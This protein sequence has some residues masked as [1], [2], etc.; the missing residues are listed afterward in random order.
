MINTSCIFAAS[1]LLCMS[2]F[3][4]FEH[5]RKR[6]RINITAQPP[7]PLRRTPRRLIQVIWQLGINDIRGPECSVSLDLT[8]VLARLSL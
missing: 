6:T 8:M 1:I 5:L 7:Y 2:F 3:I 4:P